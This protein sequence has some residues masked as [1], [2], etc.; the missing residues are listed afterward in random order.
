MQ[1]EVEVVAVLYSPYRSH[2][3]VVEGREFAFEDHYCRVDDPEDVR[4]LLS[5]FPDVVVVQT[6]ESQPESEAAVEVVEDA[7]EVYDE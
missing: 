5:S 1:R 7:A 4:R 3:L 2:R 6:S